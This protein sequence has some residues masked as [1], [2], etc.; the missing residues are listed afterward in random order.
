MT[1]IADVHTHPGDSGQSESDQAH[2]I[3]TRSGHLALIVPRFAKLPVRRAEVGVY[4][5]Q[6]SG[7]WET[8]PRARRGA[9]FHLGFWGS[10]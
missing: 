3:I 1:V 4:R 8:I 6:G 10:V 2:P 9:F 7:R 5:Y